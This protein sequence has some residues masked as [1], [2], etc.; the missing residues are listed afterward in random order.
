MFEEQITK[1][2]EAFSDQAGKTASEAAKIHRHP[3]GHLELCRWS[4]W[5]SVISAVLQHVTAMWRECGAA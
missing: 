4:Q 3:K 1:T 5:W 2:R